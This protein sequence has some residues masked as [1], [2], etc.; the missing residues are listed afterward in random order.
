[1]V[2]ILRIQLEAEYLQS[3]SNQTLTNPLATIEILTITSA[4]A[5]SLL[6]LN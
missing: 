2:A 1:M 5:I 6:Q 4:R 3:K